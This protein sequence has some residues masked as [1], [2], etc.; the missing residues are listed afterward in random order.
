M[1]L[2]LKCIMTSGH[3]TSENMQARKVHFLLRNELAETS[4]LNLYF[5][6]RDR[7]R[8]TRGSVVS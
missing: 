4:T 2:I 8:E 6:P 7:A 1:K 3:V 5:N